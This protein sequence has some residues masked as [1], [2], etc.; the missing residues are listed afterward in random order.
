MGMKDILEKEMP[1][2]RGK[3]F[4]FGHLEGGGKTTLLGISQ[5][6]NTK[7]LLA[8]LVIFQQHRRH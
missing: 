7:S 4:G 1:I 3:D 5:T 2:S 6:T 8:I